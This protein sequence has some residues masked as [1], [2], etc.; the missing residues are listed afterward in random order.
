MFWGNCRQIN[1]VCTFLHKF[2]YVYLDDI[3]I[4]PKN[5]TEHV[6]HV[7]LVH[8]RLLDHRLYTKAE[9]CEFHKT[10]LM[11]AHVYRRF[12]RS[13]STVSALLTNLL[14]GK[15]KRIDF[16]PELFITVLLY[17]I[18]YIIRALLCLNQHSQHLC[19]LK[20]WNLHTSLLLF[21]IL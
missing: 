2:N 11:S 5:L 4:Y 17:T 10:K 9:N 21:L 6:A 12:I 20:P 13:F 8:H 18:Y 1:R 19:S 7:R 16:T 15:P 14:K 3:L